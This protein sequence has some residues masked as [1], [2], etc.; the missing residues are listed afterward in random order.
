[1]KKIICIA[2]CIIISG[3]SVIY[4]KS[5]TLRNGG[6]IKNFIAENTDT[7]TLFIDG[8]V[9]KE[10]EIVINREGT[11][12]AGI[13]NPVIDAEKEKGI[14]L[15]EANDVT[16]KGITFRNSGI[17]FTEDLYGIKVFN[18]S[19]V[20]ITG[21]TVENSFFAIY[22]ANASNT[23]VS[24]N[25][26]SG[27][28]TSESF[29]GNGIHLWKCNNITIS[30]NT[31]QRQRDGIYLEFATNSLILNN[32]SSEN[33]RYGLH[34]MF[35]EGNRYILNDFFR[36]GA[37]VAVMYTKKVSMVMNRFYDNWGDNAYGLLLKDID[38]SEIYFNSFL[39]NTT[40]IYS[41]GSNKLLVRNNIFENNGWAMKILGN[42]YDNVFTG[43]AYVNNIFDL[44]T[45]TSK[46]NNKFE[47]N[48]WD[49]YKGYDLEKDGTGDVPYRPMNLFSMLIETS[50]D[51]II[52]LNSFMVEV[53]DFAEKIS[54]AFTPETLI[55]EKPLMAWRINAGS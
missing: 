16:V 13:N 8:G 49:K 12:I 54:P 53:I 35:S 21:N 30:G 29:S 38:N 1:M 48:Y 14:M 25:Y 43:N 46:N 52:L 55:D 32:K 24:D 36:N 18:S 19:G 28:S 31:I 50:P 37:G 7:D 33:L 39:K 6:S 4:S 27:N 26:I 17:S 40:G 20:R 45:N 22:L 42:C 44:A 2:W 3:S 41:E 10:R 9:Y 23:K 11:V 51:A 5:D 15:I 47:Q 34:F